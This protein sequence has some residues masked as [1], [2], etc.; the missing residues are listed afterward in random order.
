[1]VPSERP[2]LVFHPPGRRRGN[3]PRPTHTH[4]PVSGAQCPRHPGRGTLLDQRRFGRR[5]DGSVSQAEPG[6]VEANWAE[7]G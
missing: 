4:P 7:P 1:M 2:G 5:S 6:Q 3:P